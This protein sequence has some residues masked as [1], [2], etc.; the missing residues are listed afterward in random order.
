MSRLHRV[1][2]GTVVAQ[3]LHQTGF[4]DT[5]LAAEHYHLPFPGLGPLPA[6]HEQLDL[7]LSPNERSEPPLDRHIKPALRF[8]FPCDLIEPERRR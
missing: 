6:P 7:F 8:P 5:G 1:V 3:H 4:A 2:V